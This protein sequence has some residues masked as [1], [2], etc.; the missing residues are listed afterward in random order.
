VIW[1]STFQGTQQSASSFLHLRTEADQD[2]ETP[3][4]SVCLCAD[5]LT[6]NC[7]IREQNIQMRFLR[8]RQVGHEGLLL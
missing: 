6:Q 5:R 3:D 7:K 4:Y 8:N 1:V 2:S